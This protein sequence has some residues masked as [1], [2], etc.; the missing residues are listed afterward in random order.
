MIDHRAIEK[1]RPRSETASTSSGA[2]AVRI[3]AQCRRPL[4]AQSRQERKAILE[5]W[6]NSIGQALARHGGEIVPGSLSIAGQTIEAIVPIA[7]LPSAEAELAQEN[8]RVDLVT[9]RQ[10]VD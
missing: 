6:Q 10:V 3:T 9:S 4:I 2:E 1:L 8:V 7:N 5:D